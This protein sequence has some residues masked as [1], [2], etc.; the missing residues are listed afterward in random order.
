M[1]LLSVTSVTVHLF[2]LDLSRCSSLSVLRRTRCSTKRYR[3]S[4]RGEPRSRDHVWRPAPIKFLAGRSLAPPR[5]ATL[6]SC[7]VVC[8]CQQSSRLPT[9]DKSPRGG[10]REESTTANAATPVA[11]LLAVE[12]ELVS[13]GTDAKRTPTVEERTR[14]FERKSASRATPCEK[15][16]WKNGVRRGW[17]ETDTGKSRLGENGSLCSFGN[18]KPTGKSLAQYERVRRPS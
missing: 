1:T 6:Y 11:T 10:C 12:S 5:A 15:I 17:T 18:Q 3:P 13:R 16:R 2:R 7:F 4:C 9:R 8:T 14:D